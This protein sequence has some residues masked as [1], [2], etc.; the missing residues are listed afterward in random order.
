MG[1]MMMMLERFLEET[2]PWVFL[3]SVGVVGEGGC[4]QGEGEDDRQVS[5]AAA[6]Q[7][8]VNVVTHGTGVRSRCQVVEGPDL[9]RSV[10]F[11]VLVC[12]D[13]GSL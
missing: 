12:H 6:E 8:R 4:G 2:F 1:M 5:A 13:V 7:M 3:A 11:K 9:L 10:P